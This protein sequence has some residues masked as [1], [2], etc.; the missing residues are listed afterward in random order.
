LIFLT[1]AVCAQA[2]PPAPA[3]SPADA[4]ARWLELSKPMWERRLAQAAGKPTASHAYPTEPALVFLTA[5]SVTRDERYARQAAKQLDYAHDRS[6]D[7]LLLTADGLCGRD[8]QARQVYNFYL[9]YRVLREAHYLKWAEEATDATL[10]HVP[11]SPYTCRGETH[12]L[13]TADLLDRV[14]TVKLRNPERIDPNQ[15][16]GVALAFTL[17]YH[18][19][20]SKFFKS[21]VAKS[22]ACE[23]LLAGMTLQDMNTGL[24]AIAEH[25]PGGDT[26]YGA[27]AAFSWVWC[28]VLWRDPRFEPHV[29]AAG[30]WLATKTD[31]SKDCTRV[32]PEA[33]QTWVP[34][35]QANYCVPLFWYCKVEARAFIAALRERSAHPER[36]PGDDPAPLYWAYFDVMGLPRA[37][38]FDGTR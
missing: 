37:F 24:I 25:Y 16:A 26:A 31:L 32:Y 4:Q 15:N 35:W 21:E 3:T 22:I 1:A 7:G 27:Y 28:Q 14:G 38:Y 34:S 30:R 23:E 11:R 8:Y 10:R 33:Q 5:Y 20:A 18:D 13:F 9:A 19:V 36:T 12:T 29:Q 2:A 6:V 17:L